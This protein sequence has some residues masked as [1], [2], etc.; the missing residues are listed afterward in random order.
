MEENV[1]PSS[2]VTKPASAAP[3]DLTTTT[4]DSSAPTTLVLTVGRGVR[5]PQGR[6]VEVR[7]WDQV[8][9][10]AGVLDRLAADSERWWSP[11]AFLDHYRSQAGWQGAGAIAVDLDCVDLSLN[12]EARHVELTTDRR[13]ALAMFVRSGAVPGSFMYITPR[14]ARLGFVLAQMA[15]D[16]AEYL[17]A[18]EGVGAVIQEWLVAADLAPRPGRPGLELDAKVLADRAR[19]LWAPRAIVCGR[20]RQARVIRLAER[21]VAL[22]T[23]CA[24][25]PQREI[26]PAR[27]A[28]KEQR[29]RPVAHADRDQAVRRARSY[30]T[31]MGPAI[32]GHGGHDHTFDAACRIV[33]RVLD[34]DDAWA[35]LQ[36]WNELCEPPWSERELRHKLD[37]ALK[38]HDLGRLVDARRC[39]STPPARPVNFHLL[40]RLFEASR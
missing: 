35:V 13:E 29:L 33:E 8:G 16:A 22:A 26:V 39:T 7:G 15:C 6:R 17:R 25:A 34:E 40:S 20:A 9:A 23:L 10:Y 4:P 11:H 14:G 38:K 18:C 12:G 32:A 27:A 28:L 31:A 2:S 30:V 1:K 24:R 3:G 19:M 5:E 36:E 21:P 37:D